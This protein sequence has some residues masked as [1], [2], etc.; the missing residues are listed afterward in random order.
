[1][2]GSGSESVQIF[3]DPDP[4]GPKTYGTYGFYGS[5][6][7]K[8]VVDFLIYLN[9]HIC[10][11]AGSSVKEAKMLEK[12]RGL[13]A[14]SSSYPSRSGFK[15]LKLPI[16]IFAVFY[17][18]LLTELCSSLEL[19]YFYLPVEILPSSVGVS[20]SLYAK[21]LVGVLIINN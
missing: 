8:F 17:F 13:Q 15:T 16:F 10:R 18:A 4:G 7:L 19:C 2:K 20:C 1:M 12:C 5:G 3:T 6:T 21:S 14:L 11:L 9:S